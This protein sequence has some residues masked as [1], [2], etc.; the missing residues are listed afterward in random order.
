MCSRLTQP[1]YNLLYKYQ[2]FCKKGLQRRASGKE[3]R[4]LGL[5]GRRAFTGRGVEDAGGA[6]P[7]EILTQRVIGWTRTKFS[8]MGRFDKRKNLWLIFSGMQL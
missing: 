7:P 3:R 8:M 2:L 6:I 4:L 1:L 5:A